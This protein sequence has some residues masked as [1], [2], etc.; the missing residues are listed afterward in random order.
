MV[1][2]VRAW[3][4]EIDRNYPIVRSSAGRVTAY[5]ANFRRPRNIE[6]IVRSLLA[7]KA[8]GRIIVSNNDP[9]SR[10]ERWFRPASE[11]VHVL[12]HDS[13]QNCMMRFH[14]LLPFASSC[15]LIVDDDMFFYPSLI[16]AL[17]AQVAR[18]PS[19]PHGVYGQRW[20]GFRFVGGIQREDRTLDVISRVYAFT[21]EHLRK[22]IELERELLADG[23]DPADIARS[24]D[25]LLSCSGCGLP[26]I[27]DVGPL[28]DCPTQGRA[29]VASWREQG[30]H[31]DRIRMFRRIRALRPLSPA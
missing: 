8:I 23:C 17:C 2:E 13:V 31:A 16:D 6:P 18:D 15:N 29:G 26:R 9:D 20:D 25:I 1:R 5:V 14:H 19:V 10:L 4:L 27:H 30:F 21:D 28:I 24:D 12:T 7:S 3:E 22:T 11:R